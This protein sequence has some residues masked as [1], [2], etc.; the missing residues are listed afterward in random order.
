[1][2][3]QPRTVYRDIDGGHEKCP[4]LL[5]RLSEQI[6]DALKNHEARVAEAEKNRRYSTGRM[7]D[8]GRP[9]LVR[10]NLIYA[11][12]AAII[13]SVY[14]KN[15]DISVS[16]ST[17]VSPRRYAVVKQFARTMEVVLSRAFVHE[18]R[19]KQRV[20]SALYSVLNC[21]DGWLKLGFQSDPKYDPLLQ[22]RINDT[23]D[24]IAVVRRLMA[25]TEDP[26]QIS[27]HETKQAEL[28][29]ALNGLMETAE[30]AVQAGLVLDRVPSEDVL[31]LDHTI[32]DFDYYVQAEALDHMVW[33]TKDRYID[34]YGEWPKQ[35]SPS[36]YNQ[37]DL[38]NKRVESAAQKRPAELVC[39]HEVWSLRLG[40]VFTFGHGSKYWAREPYSPQRMPERWYPFFRIGWNFLDSSCHA[41]ADVSLWRELQDEY[42]KSR[43]QWAEHRE[44]SMPVR[45]VRGG[46]SLTDDDINNI[47]NRKSR[48]IVVVEGRPGDPIRNDMAELP[49][50][51]IDPAVYDTTP[52]RSDM[53]MVAG[54]GD[55]SVGGIIQAKTA[56]EAEIQQAG[57]VS[58]SDFRR[59]T[60]EDVIRDMAVAAAQILLQELTVAQV[61]YIAG[62]GAVW[63]QMAREEVFSL[64]EIEVRSGSTG[65][66]N[67]AFEQER[68]EKLLPHLRESIQMIY[69]L[70]VAGNHQ[71][72]NAMR[73]ILKETLRKY[74]ERFDL[75]E[76]LGPEQS[77]DDASQSQMAQMQQQIQQLTTAL[78]QAQQQLQSFDQEKQRQQGVDLE[79][80][81]RELALKEQQVLDAHDSAQAKNDVQAALDVQA[82][83]HR[84]AL[85]EQRREF[86]HKA[87]VAALRQQ[88]QDATSEAQRR[89]KAVEQSAAEREEQESEAVSPVAELV[90]AMFGQIDAMRGSIED[91][92]RARNERIAIVSEAIASGDQQSLRDAAR[93]LSETA[94]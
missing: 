74:D 68:W 7:H 70:Q 36:V 88:V 89:L 58:R 86:E 67:R 84:A 12:T 25:D 94:H 8:D 48:D 37:R 2:A 38:T 21:G 43:T 27:Q 3:A 87:E 33:M 24:N 19:L 78:E 15:P 66:P 26:E 34:L 60:V 65:K 46:G 73:Q 5:E 42:N 54:R 71:L 51:P 16:P 56:T 93:R 91:S 1:M 59:D 28:E 85:E 31:V 52:I 62:E 83:A 17:S 76:I 30:V 47:K 92:E 61:Q 90:Q 81:E 44:D 13:P 11:N 45:V 79:Y 4:P 6:E 32:T 55:A 35:G 14:A 75:E 41:L 29:Q 39:V 64:V 77:M 50:I 69:E 72:A 53:E 10:T 40:R 18:T 9:G 23:Q 49:A 20:R 63:P 22:A 82:A 80:R 57:L